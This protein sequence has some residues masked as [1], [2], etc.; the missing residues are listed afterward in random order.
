VLDKTGTL[1]K[2]EPEV[3]DIVIAAELSEHELLALAAAV[4]RESEHP[5]AEAIAR[6]AM[7][8]D[9]P[10]LT[11][12]AFHNV[13]GHGAGAAVDGRRVLVGNRR[14]MAS[15]GIDLGNVDQRR[16]ELAAAGR[17]AVLVAVDG[18][19]AGVLALADAPRESAAAAIRELH[20]M[21]TRSPC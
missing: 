9:V 10:L 14:L 12:S 18:R 7:E 1:T 4:E 19:A 6:R 13:P 20:A 17:T 8:Q 2:S 16:D 11:A 21:G 5:L 15:E 3:T